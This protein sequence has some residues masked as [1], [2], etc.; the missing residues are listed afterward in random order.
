VIIISGE[1]TSGHEKEPKVY[2]RRDVSCNR[3]LERE[4]HTTEE[5]LHPRLSVE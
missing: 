5:I 4:W 2:P 3:T 1:I